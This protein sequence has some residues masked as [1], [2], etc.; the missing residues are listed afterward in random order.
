MCVLGLYAVK[1]VPWP[2]VVKYQYSQK[3]FS[4][5]GHEVVPF[6]AEMFWSHA[7]NAAVPV[8][9]GAAGAAGVLLRRRAAA[10]RRRAARRRITRR[11]WSAQAV[12]RSAPL[13]S[14]T[15]PAT[16]GAALIALVRLEARPWISEAVGL[17]G[18]LST[19]PTADRYAVSR[20]SISL[21][22][23]P[24]WRAPAG[25]GR[26]LVAPCARLVA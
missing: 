10:A 6:L 11:V 5:N 25:A 18:S 9:D 3:T 26:A 23:S 14:W 24:S 16:G 20:S 1:R 7:V 4:A 13:T 15:D 17:E 21:A 2:D 12:R 19:A 22:R 8:V